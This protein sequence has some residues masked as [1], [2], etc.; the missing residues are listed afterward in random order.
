[1]EGALPLPLPLPQQPQLLPLLTVASN[2]HQPSPDVP[3]P[4]GGGGGF[5]EGVSL[6]QRCMTGGKRRKRAGEVSSLYSLRAA[7]EVR[8]DGEEQRELFG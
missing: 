8:Q 2:G 5:S 4:G 3:P 7:G 6:V 1:M